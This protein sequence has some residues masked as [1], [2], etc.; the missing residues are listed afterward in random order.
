MKKLALRINNIAVT[1]LLAL[2]LIFAYQNLSAQ[3]QS[4]QDINKQLLLDFFAFE[5]SGIDRMEQYMAEIH[6]SY[7]QSCLVGSPNRSSRKRGYSLGGPWWYK[8]LKPNYCD[9]RR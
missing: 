8:T 7:R 6:W 3:N 5:G 9:G 4:E 2:I 1:C